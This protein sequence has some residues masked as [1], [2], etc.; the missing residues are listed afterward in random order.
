MNNEEIIYSININDIQTVA[1]EEI[2]RKLTLSEIESI[3]DPISERINWFDA[4]AD[5]INEFISKE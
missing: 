2:N 5:A 3:I 4:I 1:E